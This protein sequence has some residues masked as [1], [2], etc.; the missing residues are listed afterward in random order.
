MGRCARAAVL[1]GFAA[2]AFEWSVSDKIEN[3][4]EAAAIVSLLIR[5]GE[6]KHVIDTIRRHRDPNVKAA[7]VH[8]TAIVNDDRIVPDLKRLVNEG[9]L[10][11]E[12]LRRID[13]AM[14]RLS[15]RMFNAQFSGG[16][17]SARYA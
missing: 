10:P 9:L 12:V 7:L 6:S 15:P 5:S 13:S 17:E 4:N 3:V 16:G 11:I 8:L 14:L 2:K 1:A